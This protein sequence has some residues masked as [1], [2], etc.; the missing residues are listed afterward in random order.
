MND[1]WRAAQ[2]SSAEAVGRDYLHI[3]KMLILRILL[4]I[5]FLQNVMDGTHQLV[6]VLS[7]HIQRERGEP[8]LQLMAPAT[9]TP[10][11]I[12]SS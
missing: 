2:R 8:R 4:P 12:H 3:L 11:T 10:F 1:K 9:P 5:L 7:D 6:G